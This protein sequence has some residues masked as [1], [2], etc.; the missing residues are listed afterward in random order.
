M[1]FL[2]RLLGQ[3]SADPRDENDSWLLNPRADAVLDVV[4]E[5]S[6]Q[7]ALRKLGA[8]LTEAG[9]THTDHL[10]T[11]VPEPQ[12]RYDKNAIR[13]QIDRRR[14]GYLSREN[15]LLYGPV[16]RWALGQGRP[17]VAHAKLTGGWS[18]GEAVRAS[19]GVKLHVGSPAET[20][21]E[22]LGDRLAVRSDHRWPGALVAFTGDSRCHVDGMRL[23]RAASEMLAFRAGL[24]VHPRV[25][26]KVQLLVDCDPT[27]I[28]GNESRARE[29]GIDVVTETEF[30]TELG[31]RVDHIDWSAPPT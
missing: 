3:P 8:P 12:N 10:A 23:D 24:S 1:G 22:L 21:I 2:R 31:V 26:R 18:Y 4:G 17:L 5:Q 7:D 13:V 9:P 30:W 27:G 20:L 14:I 6:Y 28:S 25:T 15:A 11:L 16:I 19:I 29:Y